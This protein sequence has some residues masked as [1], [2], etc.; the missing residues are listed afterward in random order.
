MVN[1]KQPLM[2]RG[3]KQVNHLIP[4]PFPEPEIHIHVK[5]AY[6]LFHSLFNGAPDSHDLPRALHSRGQGLIC[7]HEL[8][9]GPPGYLDHSIVHSGLKGRRRL[10]GNIIGYLVQGHADGDLCGH[11]GYGVP[12]GFAGQCR[13]AAHPWVDFHDPVFAVLYCKLDIAPA[14][15]GQASYDIDTGTAQHLVVPVRQG[16]AGS[17]H[18]ALPC[19][20]THGVDILHV[21]YHDT[22]IIGITHHLVLELFPAQNALLDEYLVDTAAF[23]AQFS[24]R[25]EFFL[26]PG[27]STASPAQ[28]IGRPDDKGQAQFIDHCNCILNGV[29]G[30]AAGYR[31]T[32]TLHGLFEQVPVLGILYGFQWCTVKF[33]IVFLKYPHPGQFTNN[34]QPGL[35][36]QSRDHS[37][38]PL[39]F[40]D[41]LNN[42]GFDGFYIH[43]ICHFRVGHDSGRVGVNEYHAHTFFPQ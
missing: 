4:L 32:D 21:A 34:V 15:D 30:L 33:D 1:A 26:C 18:N 13:G 19:M 27:N 38:W 3:R 35:P 36:P 7:G 9:K 39:L 24:D 42:F 6:S 31:L 41:A 23:Q 43:H 12:C 28:G 17:D 29:H 5:T 14:F 10:F 25:D 20:D 40:N 37:V 2:G 22:G 16:L 8:V 11:P